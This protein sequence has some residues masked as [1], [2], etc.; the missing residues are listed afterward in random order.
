MNGNLDIF[1]ITY[2]RCNYLENTLNKIFSNESPLKDYT[3][4]ILDNNSN[5]RTEILCKNFATKYQNLKYIKN[6]KNIGL[7]GNICKAMMLA[8]KKYFWILCDN[9]DLD[10]SAWNEV[11]EA[12][13]NNKDL[14]LVCRDY[15]KINKDKL[16]EAFVLNQI[17]FLPAGIYKTEY[18][19]DNVM[20]YAVADTYTILPH[21]PLGCAIL[22]NAG[23]IYLVSKSIVSLTENIKITNGKTYDFD[24]LDYS[25]MIDKN[26]RIK[27]INFY[28]G[29]ISSFD[30]CK[31][32]KIR[33]IAIKNFFKIRYFSSFI[34][35][36][37]PS[38][39]KYE[40]FAKLPFDL[41]LIYF[42][43]TLLQP[44]MY[45]I[46]FYYSGNGLGVCLF[47]KLKIR[48]FSPKWFNRQEKCA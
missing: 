40:F 36:K 48:L 46:Y 33:E 17:T 3:I 19:T 25:S 9:D 32:K 23:S 42:L 39:I 44:L 26:E 29:I 45:I 11:E 43:L 12:M 1:L 28:T 41:K 21:V 22:N 47:N 30:S 27:A 37:T 4:I 8:E 34:M 31:N 18:L 15:Y 2:N 5:D 10:F 20:S 24:R 16:F 7:A 13:T 35:S 6:K 14:I 38:Y